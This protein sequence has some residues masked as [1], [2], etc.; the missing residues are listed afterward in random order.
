MI[1]IN[2]F[3]AL[4]CS[5]ESRELFASNFYI[6][7]VCLFYVW[8]SKYTQKTPNTWVKMNRKKKI[9]TAL[10]IAQLLEMR[11]ELSTLLITTVLVPHMRPSQS[12]ILLVSIRHRCFTF[13]NLVNLS[14]NE[15]GLRKS[16]GSELNE[17]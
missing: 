6:L 5:S 8:M 1:E 14:I 7:F 17:Y 13:S 12:A 9:S 15:I 11:L 4:T 3:K 2:N 16:E 10:R